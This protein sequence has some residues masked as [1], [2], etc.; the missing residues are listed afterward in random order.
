M[1]NVEPYVA[2]YTTI[3]MTDIWESAQE[4]IRTVP[5]FTK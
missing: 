3:L 5:N 1:N 2:P 4:F